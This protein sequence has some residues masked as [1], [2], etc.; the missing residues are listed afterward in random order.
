MKPLAL[1]RR[2]PGSTFVDILRRRALEQ[3]SRRVFTLLEDGE[4]ETR[5][6]DFAELD[7]QARAIA[8][9]LQ[10]SVAAGERA[11]L[12]YPFGLDYAAAF[13][14]ALYAGV[15]AVPVYPPDP[16]RLHRTLPRLRAIA[17][18]AQ[19][20]L[21]LTTHAIRDLVDGLS[22]QAPEARRPALGGHRRV[23]A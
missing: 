5:H 20:T 12:L 3:P 1:V 22:S 11:L 16:S 8:A 17:Q 9:T 15:V 18:D 7:R 4:T 6:L 10:R 19:A 21:V 14:G 13:F 2:E 23:G